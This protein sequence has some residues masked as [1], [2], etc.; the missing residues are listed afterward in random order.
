MTTIRTILGQAVACALTLLL[1]APVL[2]KADESLKFDIATQPL[3][4]ALKAFAEQANMQ[5]LYKHEAVE[6]ATANAVIGQ[7][8]K[9]EALTQLVRGTGLEIV[10]T[11]DNA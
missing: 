4:P 10:F 6:S 1:A 3:V 11:D 9:R 8:D 5:L 2:A 7:Y